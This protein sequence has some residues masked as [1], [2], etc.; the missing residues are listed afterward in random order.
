MTLLILSVT[1]ATLNIRRMPADGNF[2]FPT[3]AKR[4]TKFMMEQTYGE[5]RPFTPAWAQRAVL[6][7]TAES[8]IFGRL[9]YYEEARA[10][11][12]AC[13][14]IFIA[15]NDNGELCGFADVGAS[16]W[17][18][19]DQCHRLPMGADLQRLATTGRGTDGQVKNGVE[20]RPYVSNLVVD[21]TVRR[22]GVGRRLMEACE[23]DAASW[24]ATCHIAE[25]KPAEDMWL[26]VT[27]TNRAAV[28]FYDAIGYRS[29]GITRGPEMVRQGDGFGMTDVERLVLRKALRLKGGFAQPTIYGRRKCVASLCSAATLSLPPIGRATAFPPPAGSAELI[30]PLLQCRDLL[31]VCSAAVS[32][33]ARDTVTDWRELQRTLNRPPITR[34]AGKGGKASVVVGSGFRAASLAYDESLKYVAEL[35]EADRAFCYVSKAV[36]VD[37]QCVQRLYTSDRTYR[38]LLRNSVL[39]ELQQLEGEADYLA[40]C[41]QQARESSGPV[42][43]RNDGIRCSAELADE[44]QLE[45]RRL[46]DS[47]LASLDKFFASI[48]TAE[49]NAARAMMVQ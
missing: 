9:G 28:E 25:A 41:E 30:V 40:L 4:L 18:P 5:C 2:L 47:T 13:G 32:T 10:N 48:R 17:L 43:P 12:R 1:A 7:G 11:G 33:A 45:V 21:A 29:A 14:S 36:K 37:E 15:E 19:N 46:L 38:E 39:T 35:D 26:E 44:S 6:D 23:E 16:L 42:D 8:D 31:G 34:P 27:S 22:S 24:Q 20:L 3:G 49:I